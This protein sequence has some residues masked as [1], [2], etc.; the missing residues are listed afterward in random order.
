[1]VKNVPPISK[2]QGFNSYVQVV[3]EM[4]S[5]DVWRDVVERTSPKTRRFI[6][7]PPMPM[8]WMS[9]EHWNELVLILRKTAF[10]GKPELFVEAGQR[11]IK[12]DLSTLY[13]VLMMLVSPT[14]VVRKAATIYAAYTQNGTMSAKS[15]GER[16]VE[17]SVR[18][19][20]DH[21]PEVWL[22]HV[23]SITGTLECAGAKGI[24]VK[25]VQ[26]GGEESFCVYEA[27]WA[28]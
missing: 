22:H 5:P 25:A 13:K 8:Q 16:K 3:S 20:E 24:Q 10:A 6:D 27:V 21:L 19:V 28:R 23:G 12:R 1:M 15:I 14:T 17:V 2:A 11:Q 26:G 18:G 7:E 4:M 9:D